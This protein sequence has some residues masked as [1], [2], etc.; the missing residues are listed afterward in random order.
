[1]NCWRLPLGYA[2]TISSV[3]GRGEVKNLCGIDSVQPLCNPRF[4][5]LER[6]QLPPRAEEAIA[7]IPYNPL[8]G[9]LPGGKHDQTAAPSEGTHFPLG[10]PGSQYQR[11]RPLR[12]PAR[13]RPLQEATLDCHRDREAALPVLTRDD[14]K[15]MGKS[16]EPA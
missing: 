16:A 2:S 15:P 1:M 11:L 8:A 14:V 13:R 7:L 6:D 12:W 3:R 4:R 5:S 9:C 10:N